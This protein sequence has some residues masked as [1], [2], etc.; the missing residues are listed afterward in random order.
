MRQQLL[1]PDPSTC[2]LSAGAS[3]LILPALSSAVPFNTV[4]HEVVNHR[5]V[6]ESG[7]ERQVQ[8]E[9]LAGEDLKYTRIRYT[10]KP[11]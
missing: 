3:F 1:H 5:C 11:P 7:R 2:G 9:D 6:L 10:E 8:M 4:A